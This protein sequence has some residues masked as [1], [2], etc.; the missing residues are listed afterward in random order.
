L[1]G[2]RRVRLP[3]R[4]F[5]VR[6]DEEREDGGLEPRTPKDP[7]QPLDPD[8]TEPGQQPSDPDIPQEPAPS[9]D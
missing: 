3:R 5:V 4:I 6:N 9:D 7:G 1:S 8:V 2:D